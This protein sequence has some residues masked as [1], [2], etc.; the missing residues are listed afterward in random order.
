MNNSD[1]HPTQLGILNKLLFAQSLRY[2]DLKIDPEME[3]NTFQFHLDK[4]VLMGYVAKD[5]DGYALTMQGKKIANFIKTEHNQMVDVRKVSACLY[6]VRDNDLGKETLIYT[7]LK[8][9]FYGKQGF[10]T[11]KIDHGE[12]FTDAAKR[13]LYEETKLVGEPELFQIVHYLVSD[14]QSGELLDDKLFFYYLFRNPSGKLKGSKEGDYKWVPMNE[15]EKH[16][17]KPFDSIEV[18]KEEMELIENFN[19]EVQFAE[20]VHETSEF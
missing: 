1:L 6:C 13:E 3:N 18:Y 12:V 14:E 9:Q 17:L 20:R 8:H 10:P 19:G 15:I 5:D 16:I 4:V 2:S 11:G 7:R